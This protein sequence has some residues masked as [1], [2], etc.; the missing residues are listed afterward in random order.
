MSSRRDTRPIDRELARAI[1]ELHKRYPYL[2]SAGIEK[3]LV[4][5]GIHVEPQ[6]MRVFMEK[7]HIEAQPQ[8]TWVNSSDPIQ[9]LRAMYGSPRLVQEP[10]RLSRRKSGR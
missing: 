7:H 3:L 8:A 1:R 4:K 5:A 10:I 9:A 6:E 2:G